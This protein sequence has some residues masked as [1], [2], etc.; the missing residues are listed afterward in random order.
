MRAVVRGAAGARTV[1]LQ[2]ARD[3]GALSRAALVDTATGAERRA[4]RWVLRSDADRPLSSARCREAA[5]A[6]RDV[7]LAPMEVS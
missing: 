6:L 5:A 3:G 4:L 2:A 7:V 1:L